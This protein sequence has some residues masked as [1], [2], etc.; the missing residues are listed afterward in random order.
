MT[1]WIYISFSGD[2]R[3]GYA[4]KIP[5]YSETYHSYRHCCEF[6]F[7]TEECLANGPTQPPTSGPSTIESMLPSSQPS[8]LLSAQPSSVPSAADAPTISPTTFYW[9]ALMVSTTIL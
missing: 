3:E 6:S 8:E 4:D 7:K 1:Y 2:C 9:G 5:H